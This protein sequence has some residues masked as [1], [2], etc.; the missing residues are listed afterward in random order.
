MPPLCGWR[1]DLVC[2]VPPTTISNARSVTA[3]RRPRKLKSWQPRR[4]RGPLIR[5]RRQPSRTPLP[6]NNEKQR[7][8]TARCMIVETES[9]FATIGELAHALEEGRTT[10]SAIV[11]RALERVEA[12]PS[13]NAFV[14][15]FPE[16]AIAA[17]E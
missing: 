9:A 14:M 5:Q 7:T 12:H 17:A 15:T 4:R 8:D 2:P 10:S 6:K 11:R 3:S 1:K 16:S 13:L